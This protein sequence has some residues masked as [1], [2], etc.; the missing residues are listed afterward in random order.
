MLCLDQ[1]GQQKREGITVNRE[2]V[3]EFLWRRFLNVDYNID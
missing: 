1:R 2:N 3:E